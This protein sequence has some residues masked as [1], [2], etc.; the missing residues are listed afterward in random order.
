MTRRKP[1]TSVLRSAAFL[2]ALCSFAPA[3]VELRGGA[4]IDQPVESVSAAGVALAQTES[5]APRMLGWHQVKRVGGDFADEAEAFARLSEDLWR[6][7]SRLDRGDAELAA[8]I[9]ERL[10]AAALDNETDPH[11]VA[12]VRLE[13][14]TGLAIASGA[15]RV[16]I[17]E[18]ALAEAVEP[19][20]AAIALRGEEMAEAGSLLL[21]DLPPIFVRSVA[22]E[23][24]AATEPAAVIQRD[25]R[26]SAVF[27]L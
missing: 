23:R 20:A 19:W 22:D 5:A 26:A 9:F 11:T 12:G 13:G 10:W 18:Q 3:Q 27:A 7:S 8:P 17:A 21:P 1:T 14:P 24:L 4:F 2:A 16:R 15:A 25:P 6:A